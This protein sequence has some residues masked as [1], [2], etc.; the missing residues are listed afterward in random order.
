MTSC[1]KKGFIAPIAAAAPVKME[2]IDSNFD[3]S[4]QIPVLRLIQFNWSIVSMS[5]NSNNK[6]TRSA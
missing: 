6:V 1:L 3:R 2:S 5:Y 4:S